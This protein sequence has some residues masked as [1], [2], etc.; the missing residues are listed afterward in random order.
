MHVIMIVMYYN[1]INK[2][3]FIQII[4]IITQNRQY[5]TLSSPQAPLNPN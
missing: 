5:Y 2:S 3:N 4:T 1:K